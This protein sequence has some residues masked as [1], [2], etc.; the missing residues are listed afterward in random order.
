[1]AVGDEISVVGNIEEYS[2]LTE[3][4][5]PILMNIKSTGNTP[6]AATTVT[7]ADLADSIAADANPAEPYE[8]VL[9]TINNATVGP[10]WDFTGSGTARYFEIS[11]DGNTNV[12]YVDDDAWYQFGGGNPVIGGATY[13]ITGIASY[14][15]SKFTLNPRDASDIGLV[16]VPVELS[17]FNIE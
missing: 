13:N 1:M 16:V 4:T 7:C 14:Y 17:V 10:G 15:S 11:D 12:V 8:S 3:L 2:T 6:Y 9:V 5:N